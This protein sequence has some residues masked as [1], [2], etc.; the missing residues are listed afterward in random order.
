MCT[1]NVPIQLDPTCNLSLL[2][3]L[4][5]IIIYYP[6][7]C[8]ITSGTPSH[9]SCVIFILFYFTGIARLPFLRT[10]NVIPVVVIFGINFKSQI[11]YLSPLSS[12]VILRNDAGAI[13]RCSTI[14]KYFVYVTS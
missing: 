6:C 13:C 8:E 11:L 3:L 5:F 10:P 4:L 7:A 2:Y 1:N 14:K 12:V 9:F